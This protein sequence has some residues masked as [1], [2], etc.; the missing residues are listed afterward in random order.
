[1]E[2]IVLRNVTK[3]FEVGE[4]RIQALVDVNLTVKNGQFLAV[5][6]SSGSGKSTLLNILGC[7]DSPTSGE[8]VL[9]GHRVSDLIG[10]DLAG[11]R[12]QRIG[13]VFQGFNLLARTTALQN[14]ELPLM[15]DRNRRIKDPGKAARA[16]LERVGLS[17]RFD[18]VP[19]QLSGGQQQRVAIARALVAQPAILLADEPTGNLDSRTSLEIMDL[20]QDLNREGITIVMVT[21]EPNLAEYAERVIEMRDGTIISNRKVADHR[22]AGRDLASLPAP[23]PGTPGPGPDRQGVDFK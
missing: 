23:V 8:Y 9:E 15:Y 21:H 10:S 3:I 7:L 11:I 5:M 2:T 19:N 20:F 4:N 6:G 16:A 13:F 1:M 18:H 22:E 17:G 14:V 12:N